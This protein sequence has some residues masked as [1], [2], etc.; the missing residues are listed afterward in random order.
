M[1]AT[2]VAPKSGT[3]K[4]L[5]A[6]AALALVCATVAT[7]AFA[8]KLTDEDVSAA[9]TA[10]I[11]ARSKDGVFT[12]HDAK[13]G[14]NVPLVLDQV[15]MVRGMEGYGWFPN[16]YFHEKDAPEKK[17]AVDFWLKPDGGE[18]KLME[19]RIHKDPQP[20]GA[21]WMMITRAPL[22]WW[23]LPTL[24]RASAVAG[25]QAWQ[26]MGAVH[27]HIAN[28]RTDGVF[29]L[30]DESGQVVSLELVDV[31]QPVVRSKKDSG[32]FA[33]AEFRK[34]GG[35]AGFHAVDLKL[36]QKTGS[37]RAGGLTQHEIPL[38]KD[39]NAAP[40]PNCRFEGAALEVVD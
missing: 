38:A 21:S 19:M 14:M 3:L 16:V 25:M 2:L 1:T 31:V 22:A 36:D 29:K 4:G 33:C 35:N 10:L 12:L 24:E 28:V 6:A 27:Q 18:L 39:G 32:Y 17:Y 20:D 40:L 34:I 11:E 15:R 23:W 13:S 9:V 7:S 5:C 37:V 30:A 26:V 8:K